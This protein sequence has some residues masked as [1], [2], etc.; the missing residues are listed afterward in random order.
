MRKTGKDEKINK[1]DLS[2]AG[3]SVEIYVNGDPGETPASE[4]TTISYTFW[5]TVL[6][7]LAILILI[8]VVFKYYSDK[9][10]RS[11]IP[12]APATPSMAA[13]ITPE[14]GS[15][16]VVSDLSPRTPQPFMDYVRRTIDETPYYRR[17]PRRRVNPQNTF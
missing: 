1:N 5:P 14:R 7:G 4:T 8:V 9:P 3:Q 15:P 12:V 2:H 11:H 17:E 13:P 16:A 10:D 6:G